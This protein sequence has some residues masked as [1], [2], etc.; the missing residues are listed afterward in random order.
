MA[1]LATLSRW[2]DDGV[3]LGAAYTIIKR[4][5]FDGECYPVHVA[6]RDE[7]LEKLAEFKDRRGHSLT[8]DP[9]EEVYNLRKPKDPQMVLGRIVYDL[10]EV[11]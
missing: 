9:V 11:G 3:A 2:F 7:A 5:W 1:D 4:D 8:T 6:T 10:E